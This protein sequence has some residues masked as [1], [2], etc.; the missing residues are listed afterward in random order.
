MDKLVIIDGNSILNRAFYALPIL[1]NKN[2]EYC[3]AIYGFCNILTKIITTE[4]PN[5]M[6]ICFDAGKRTFRNDI[7]EDYK[8]TRKNMPVELADQLAPLKAIL[9]AMN[10]FIVEQMGVEA[11]DLI[12]SIAKRFNIPTVI[13]S[14]DRDLL[15]LID[16]ST[17]VHLTKKGVTEVDVMT[18][19]TLQEKMGLKPYQIVELKA[20]MGD[21][22][23]NIPGVAGVGEKTALNLIQT[24]SDIDNLY[25]NI[26]N[27][28][29]KLKEKLLDGKTSAY[30]S[31]TLAT[32]NSNV[33][34]DVSLEE[35]KFD[36]PFGYPVYKLFAY[37]EFNSLISRTNI[38]I[39]NVVN[40]GRKK[41][42]KNI[43][44]NISQLNEFSSKFSTNKPFAIY[45][46]NDV[47]IA[48][49]SSTEYVIKCQPMQDLF[50]LSLNMVLDKM[51]V[52]L[53]NENY[54]KICFNTKSLMHFLDNFNISLKGVLFDVCIGSYLVNGSKKGNEKIDFYL[55]EFDYDS[56]SIGC[57]LCEAYGKFSKQLKEDEMETLYY[58]LEFPLV[59][60]LYDMENA[61]FKI[62]KQLLGE[63]ISEYKVKIDILL[64]EIFDLAGM[65]FNVNSPKQVGEVLFDKLLLTKPKKNAGTGVDIL[66]KLKGAHPVVEKILEYRKVVKLY[67]TYLL[68]FEK[69]LDS[70]DLIHTV[71]NQTLTSTG[72]LSSTEP[73]LQNIP[74]KTDEGRKLRQLF[75]P[76]TSN[77]YIISADY[78]QIELR[79]LAHYSNDPKLVDA[80]KSGLDIH[81]KT[82]SD[83]FGVP[84]EQVTYEQRRK[85]KAVNFGIIYGISEYGLSS[86][87]NISPV[88]AKGYINKYF[89]TYPTVKC[90]MENCV[91]LAKEKGY[92]Q[93][94]FNRRRKVDELK[95]QNYQ[96]RMFGERVSMNMPLQGSASDIIKKAMLSV[97]SEIQKRNLKSKLILQIHDELI[98][99]TVF[100]EKEI[101]EQILK[102]CMENVVK[103]NVPLVVDISCGKTWFEA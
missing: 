54:K 36:F 62:N 83:V 6:A 76:R 77:G 48:F 72:R 30:M 41:T 42:I 23:D 98:V 100:E 26:D 31:K 38:F 95:S 101:V 61:G 34:V 69:M 81:T 78:S 90:F 10:I 17:E 3:N 49:D 55:N 9:K 44:D 53:E 82:A 73:N 103:L 2:G 65:Q 35:L 15:Q 96:M 27:I 93:T 25:D 45:I 57:F 19:S 37:Y 46:E 21:A 58:D 29:G 7:Y 80:Y 92:A 79:I 66:E 20:L 102:D 91:L 56:D 28:K 75:I 50:G 24:Y 5:Y 13:L 39:E 12:G 11:D 4:K 47:H 63:F 8:G 85:A 51:K 59:N 84:F 32:I 67:N 16:S 43:I 88:E 70:N 97:E 68:D 86:N 99:D 94:L 40:A 60:V 18:E 64:Q 33:E 74:V 87:L 22:S 14:G 89:E 52:I 1:T 71:F